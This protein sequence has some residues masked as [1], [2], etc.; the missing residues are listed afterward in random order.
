MPLRPHRRRRAGRRATG[1]PVYCPEIEVPVLADIMAFVPWPGFG[2]YESYE[3][4]ETVAGGETLE[5]A[6]LRDRRR[7]SPRATAPATSP[8]RSATRRR[9]S[10][11]TSSSRARSGASTCPAA[12]GRP[13][14]SRI[15]D[16]GRRPSRRRRRSIP[17][18]WGSRRSAPSGPPTRSWPSWRVS[19]RASAMSTAGS[20]PRGGP[21]TSCPPRRRA[22]RGDR[23]VAAPSSSRAP[24]T[25]GSRRRPSRT[26]SCSRAA[27]ARAPTSSAR[28]CSPS[29]TRAGAASPCA[30]RGPRAICRAY[31][32]HGMH[33]L[34]QPVKL[35]YL[36]PVLPPRAPAGGPL[37]PVPPA[38][39][40]GD[41]LRLA[42]GRRR[43]DHAARRAA[44]RA[45]ACPALR[46]R[47]GSLGSPASRAAY[48]EELR[49]Y[50]RAHEG[51]LADDVRERIDENPLRAFD[52][53]DEGD[54][55]GDGRARRRCS[56]ASTS[57]G[58]RALRRG[59]RPARP[60][61]GRRT[62]STATLVRG[63]DYY[64]RTVF[65]FESERARRPVA[66]SAAAAATTGWSSSSAG[67]RR[68]AAAG[69]P[70]SSGSCWRST[71]PSRSRS[72]DVFVAAPSEQR[73]RAFA[74]VQR[75][76]RRRAARRARPRRA[77]AQGPDEA[78][79]PARR[80]PRRDPR[81]RRRGRAARHDERRAARARPRARAGGARA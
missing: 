16:A 38:R 67:R 79:R 52:S 60:G 53:K 18:T 22:A 19:V 69:P 29:T 39:R 63:L 6:G 33:K 75:A 21:S 76:A 10:P 71:S 32:E 20:R 4:D 30:R 72:R 23:R 70:G 9:C 2:P 65:E 14:S 68:P 54:A 61:R 41:R 31:V 58:R 46:L 42:A 5:L 37:P 66:S 50:L 55:R 48:R 57:D 74:L 47:L 13:C 45:S 12:T 43:A 64:T 77:L 15:R 8:T 80:P 51:E 24:A 27:S 7:S 73:E 49:A 34:P 78:G 44:P 62:S 56:S 81:R 36:G 11:A 59:P 3:A 26:P 28:R 25:G 1:A 35:W 40:R 17:A